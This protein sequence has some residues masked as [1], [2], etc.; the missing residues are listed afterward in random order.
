MTWR[1]NPTDC[2]RETP[3]LALPPGHTRES[4]FLR[5]RR[6]DGPG[7]ASRRVEKASQGSFGRLGPRAAGLAAGLLRF[8]GLLLRRGGKGCL[9][10]RRWLDRCRIT[11]DLI[12]LPDQVPPPDE[13]G[14][15]A[16]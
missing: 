12:T 13:K 3:H 16:G 14:R 2:W 11:D 9:Q 8:A 1:S 4:L 5:P 10:P 15:D 6:N 7:H